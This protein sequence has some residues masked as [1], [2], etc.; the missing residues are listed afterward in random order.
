[1]KARLLLAFLP[2]VCLCGPANL[3]HAQQSP[4][5]A[6]SSVAHRPHCRESSRTRQARSVSP[7]QR[8]NS[9]A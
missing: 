5:P 9:E 3:T 7:G 4:V 8:S 1:M 2:A 6:A